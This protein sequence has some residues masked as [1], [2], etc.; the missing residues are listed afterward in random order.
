MR[1]DR[2]FGL[3]SLEWRPD[4]GEAGRGAGFIKVGP[5]GSADADSADD[6]AFDFNGQ[7]SAKDQNLVV[8][9]T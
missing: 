7:A 3:G 4:T 5:G 6:F 8:H 9:V 2:L 1:H